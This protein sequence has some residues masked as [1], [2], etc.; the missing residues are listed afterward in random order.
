MTVLLKF[1]NSSF[2]M[3]KNFKTASI[4]F[5]GLSLAFIFPN[6]VMAESFNLFR[7]KVQADS[8]TITEAEPR[9]DLWETPYCRLK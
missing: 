8:S 5:L 9:C 6:S 3:I 1:C 7:I 2:T 4:L